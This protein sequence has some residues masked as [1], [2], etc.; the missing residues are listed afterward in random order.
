MRLCL[1]GASSDQLAPVYFEKTAELGR[2]MAR[3]RAGLVFGGG[4]TGLMGAAARAVHQSGGEIIGIAPKFF[5]TEGVLFQ[6]C[7]E[8]M[9]TQTM[10][11]RKQ[12]MEDMS[13]GFIVSPG[14]IGTLEEFFEI[15]TLRQLSRHKKPIAI[16]NICGYYDKL[17][18]LL[19]HT[20]SEGFM[21][22]DCLNL[23]GVYDEP[24]PLL[25]YLAEELQTALT[26]KADYSSK[27]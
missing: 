8:R 26:S 7:T 14:G 20:V 2:E 13:D 6:S 25:D 15:Y 17:L 11:Q 12:L 24:G 4:A 27:K 10:R 18:E 5:D 22:A 19:Q 1:F 3:R 16:Y 9:F 23:V 21:S